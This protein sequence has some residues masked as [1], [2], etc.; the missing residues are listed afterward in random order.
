[1]SATGTLTVRAQDTFETLFDAYVE[2]VTE[3]RDQDGRLHP[4]GLFFCD[5]RT[6][7]DLRRTPREATTGSKRP[8][9]VGKVLHEQMQAA[10]EHA[11]GRTIR[12]LFV[13]G[14]VDDGDSNVLGSF[15]ALYELMDGTWELFEAK[16]A[17]SYSFR[18]VSKSG[19][20]KPEHVNQALTYV[21]YVRTVGF[22]FSDAVIDGL[23]W[24][25]GNFGD[26]IWKHEPI[27]ELSRARVVYLDKDRHATKEAVYVYDDRWKEEHLD[28]LA[29]L[30]R[31]QA[32]GVALPP[33]LPSGSWQCDTR[34][35]PFFDRCQNVDEEGVELD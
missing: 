15:D 16:T 13:E 20:A 10:L 14:R 22:W 5:R 34:W 2:S 24:S 8:L 19:E 27:P 33:R 32:D 26:A 17:N 9:L 25:G 29:R 23:P 31:Y 21:H 1:M 3:D 30:G 12:T 28:H 35:C 18:M 11:V 7:Y 4:S 6:V